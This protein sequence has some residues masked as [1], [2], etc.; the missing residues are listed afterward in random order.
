MLRLA[1]QIGCGVALGN[2][3]GR[4]QVLG[5]AATEGKTL[6]GIGRAIAGNIVVAI[7]ACFA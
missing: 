1:L 2:V 7:R 3:P 5:D 4:T 6:T